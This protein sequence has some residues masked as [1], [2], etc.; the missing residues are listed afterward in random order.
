MVPLKRAIRARV[1]VREHDRVIAR[2]RIDVEARVVDEPDV[3]RRV[4]RR[5]AE[6]LR[7]PAIDRRR[8]VR[9]VASDRAKEP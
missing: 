4:R 8:E 7:R 2:R 3:R 6:R 9:P 5:R 1:G